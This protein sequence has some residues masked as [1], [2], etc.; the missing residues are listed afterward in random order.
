MT[1]GITTL[2]SSC[3]SLCVRAGQGRS[4]QGRAGRG[5]AGQGRAHGEGDVSPEVTGGK[6]TICA[7]VLDSTCSSLGSNAKHLCVKASGNDL[8]TC[9]MITHHKQS[10]HEA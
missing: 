8:Q 9:N 6:R 7:E 3:S 1:C 2:H 5:G 4:E 10:V